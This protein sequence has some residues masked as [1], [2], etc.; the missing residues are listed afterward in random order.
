[1]NEKQKHSP[2]RHREK[3]RFEP[4]IKVEKAKVKANIQ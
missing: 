2:Q 4:R 1:M 3:Q